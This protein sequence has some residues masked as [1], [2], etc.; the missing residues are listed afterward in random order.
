MPGQT[1]GDAV[2]AREQLVSH[3]SWRVRRKLNGT[4]LEKL[5]NGGWGVVVMLERS[6]RRPLPLP[7]EV[8]GV[9]IRI[10][11]TG[12]TRAAASVT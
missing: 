3:L 4:A 1:Y 12:P 8:A 5:A 10:K 11:T 6:P 7:S 9:P 2:S